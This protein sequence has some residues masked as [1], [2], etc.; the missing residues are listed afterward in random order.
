MTHA[1]C[2]GIAGDIWLLT[3]EDIHYYI[4][5]ILDDLLDSHNTDP[6]ASEYLSAV[7]DHL[8][9]MCWTCRSGEGGRGSETEGNGG[10]H[11]SDDYL[12]SRKTL[13]YNAFSTE[14]CCAIEQWL[15]LAR[16][17]KVSLSC[18]DDFDAAIT[19]WRQRKRGHPL[20]VPV[21]HKKSL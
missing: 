7:V 9:V 16:E 19:Y 1:A 2:V 17:W 5:R 10:W 12:A 13:L 8:N 3:A 15:V 20:E 18:L 4:P 11:G 14:Q 21:K 6:K